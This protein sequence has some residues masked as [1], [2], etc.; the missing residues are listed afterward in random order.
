VTRVFVERAADGDVAALAELQRI[1]FSHPWTRV[2]VAD[3]VGLGPPGAVLVARGLDDAGRVGVRAACAYRV[4]VDEMTIVDLSVD[5][6]WRGLGLGRLLLRL[7]LRRA[8]RVGARRALLEVRAGN[9]PALA[10]YESMGF[11]RSGVRRDYYSEPVEDAVLLER[12]GLGS[13]TEP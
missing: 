8:A 7:A 11:L 9:A 13:E 3:E 10:L 6:A 4:I 12:G 1:S 5:P 2:Q